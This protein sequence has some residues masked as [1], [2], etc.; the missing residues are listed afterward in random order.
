MRMKAFG[1]LAALLTVL[2]TDAKGDTPEA[3]RAAVEQKALN[4]FKAGRECHLSYAYFHLTSRH[5]YLHLITVCLP[6]MM[7]RGQCGDPKRMGAWANENY[8]RKISTTIRDHT[9]KGDGTTRTTKDGR[10]IKHEGRLQMGVA[11]FIRSQAA[12]ETNEQLNA[13]VAAEAG[14][15]LPTADEAD[16]L[17]PARRGTSLPQRRP[18][19]QLSALRAGHPRAGAQ[20]AAGPRNPAHNQS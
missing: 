1:A 9:A 19:R 14:I 8:Q 5:T 16:P 2:L 3:E 18:G 15:Q 4:I 11:R 10:V 12:A 7:L 20:A 17:R 6:K 13:A